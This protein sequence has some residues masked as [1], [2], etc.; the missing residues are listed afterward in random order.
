MRS[1]V[2]T[3]WKCI[4]SLKER[5]R[6]WTGHLDSIPRTTSGL[7]ERKRLLTDEEVIHLR[8]DLQFT[9]VLTAAVH[10]A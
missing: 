6:S 5:E 2:F 1:L 9:D 10:N 4:A 8:P 3:S 7:K